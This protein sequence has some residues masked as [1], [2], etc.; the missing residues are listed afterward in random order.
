M[1]PKCG[2]ERNGRPKRS[3][4]VDQEKRSTSQVVYAPNS[5]SEEEIQ[6]AITS[7]IINTGNYFPGGYAWEEML[8]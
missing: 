8:S 5:R 3:E 1:A 7:R 4:R 2:G 6:Q